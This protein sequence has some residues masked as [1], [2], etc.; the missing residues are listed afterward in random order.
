MYF[1]RFAAF[2]TMTSVLGVRTPLQ[3]LSGLTGTSLHLSKMVC[4]LSFHQKI[5]GKGARG[6]G[7]L[8]TKHNVF[9]SFCSLHENVIGSGGAKA[10]AEALEVN[11][12]LTSL[13]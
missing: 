8:L 4:S 7:F 12:T 11:T 13:E 5:E 10:I 2:A 1:S 6:L 9:F 3:K